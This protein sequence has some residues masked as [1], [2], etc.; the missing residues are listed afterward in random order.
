MEKILVIDDDEFMRDTIVSFLLD[1]GLTADI[2][3]NG[4]E[5]LRIFRP[6]YHKLVITDRRMPML[7]GEEVAREIKR[8]SPGT[9]VAMMSGDNPKEVKKVGLEAGVDKIFFKPFNLE[10]IRE[11]VNKIVAASR[12]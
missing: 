10:E 11:V 1:I 8:L 4:V 6:D 5:G 2:A 12:Q 3:S 7:F 9:F